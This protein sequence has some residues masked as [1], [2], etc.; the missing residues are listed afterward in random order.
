MSKILD[1]REFSSLGS[2]KKT[3]PLSVSANGTVN[4]SVFDWAPSTDQNWTNQE[5]PEFYRVKKFFSLY[6]IQV[7]ATKEIL[8]LFIA[9]IKVKF[10]HTSA[11]SMENIYWT[12][13]DW[14]ML[15][16]LSVYVNSSTSFALKN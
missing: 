13:Q 2:S 4:N 11:K 10:L 5:I 14:L 1:I 16:L 9:T 6:K 3:Q 7:L 8:G 15:S 12:A